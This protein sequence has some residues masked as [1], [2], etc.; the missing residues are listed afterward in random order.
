MFEVMP[1]S[2]P[3]VIPDLSHPTNPSDPRLGRLLAIDPRD[4]RWLLPSPLELPAIRKRVWQLGPILDQ[5]RTSQCVAY[6]CQ[7]FLS[8]GPVVNG[9]YKTAKELYRQCQLVDEWPGGEP[10]YFGTSVRAGF[11]ILKG[12]GYIDSYEWAFDL[13]AA[14]N[15]LLTVGP[16]VVGTNWYES[17]YQ[18]DSKGFCRIISGAR[19]V[20]GHAWVAYGVD[21]D[22]YCPD[23]TKGAIKMAN[24]WGLRGFGKNGTADMSLRDFDKLIRAWGEVGTSRE[25]KFRAQESLVL[26]S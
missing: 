17:M 13:N 9:Y 12:A 23:R 18:V 7:Q 6:A 3:I 26:P 21:R 1:M 8:C 25:I 14:L 15:H 4:R 20:G 16:L 10:A 11:I 5:G 22:I 24:S 19:N 2:S